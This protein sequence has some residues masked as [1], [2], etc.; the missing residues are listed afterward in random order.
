MI[1]LFYNLLLSC[2]LVTATV[3]IHFLG[4]VLL[5]RLISWHGKTVAN[6]HEVLRQC[7]LLIMAVLG[8]VFL[9]TIEIWSYA[10]VFQLL[11]AVTGF[12]RALYFSTVTFSS[13]GYG[14]I[15]LNPQWRV[16]G[17]IEAANGVIL[18]GWSTAFLIS[19]MSKLRTLEHDWLEK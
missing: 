14:D 18:F 9:H 19:L 16:F 3:V 15:T 13:L 6:L 12:E 7:V 8:I 11:G 2:V 4:L 10:F 5:L 1:S 17:A